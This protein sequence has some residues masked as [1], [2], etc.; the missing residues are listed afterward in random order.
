MGYVQQGVSVL[1]SCVGIYDLL[2]WNFCSGEPSFEEGRAFVRL[3]LRIELIVCAWCVLF[4]L[5]KSA[6]KNTVIESRPP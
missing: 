2:E 6:Y 4:L 5:K 3:L 1:C